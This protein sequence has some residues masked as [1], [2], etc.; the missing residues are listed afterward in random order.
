MK[1]VKSLSFDK[2]LSK[3]NDTIAKTAII[4]RIDKIRN[5]N[6]IGDYKHI[7]G[8]IF[9]LRIF[10]SKGYRLYFTA[11]NGELIILLCGGDK[12]T[13]DRDISKAKEILKDYL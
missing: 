10:V 6:H 7:E 4:R 11:K 3:L 13:Q 2:W 9:E 12:D 8:E 1:V 5:Q